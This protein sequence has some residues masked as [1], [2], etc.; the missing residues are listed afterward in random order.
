M[1]K[2]TS[3]AFDKRIALTNDPVVVRA[4]AVSAL[5]THSRSSYLP[6]VERLF[7]GGP[8]KRPEGL[9]NGL[10]HPQNQQIFRG[11]RTPYSLE[12]R[13]DG[14]APRSLNTTSLLA[15]SQRSKLSKP[16]LLTNTV[17]IVEIS[18]AKR[19]GDIIQDHEKD[20]VNT[21]SKSVCIWNPIIA[22]GICDTACGR[23]TPLAAD[24]VWRDTDILG[25]ADRH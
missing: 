23:D 17:E 3:I 10:R 25:F 14:Y 24:S 5:P 12:F 4:T 19:V 7:R 13:G 6:S 18:R 8:V 15:S 21:I 16:Y 9:L 22:C 20:S 2:R 11:P 1:P